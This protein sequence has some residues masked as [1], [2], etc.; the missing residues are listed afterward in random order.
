MDKDY[1][2]R[3][4]LGGEAYDLKLS[5]KAT[6]KITKRYGGLE[7]LGDKLLEADS[8]EQIIDEVVWL[9]TLLANQSIETFNF[10]HPDNQK[11]LLTEDAVEVFA[12]PK[13]LLTYRGAIIEALTK[14]TQRHIESEPD[15][16]NAAVG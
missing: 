10:K 16:K 3:I 11:S 12:T 9:V 6:K 14:G 2:S 1:T 15:P 13:D 8:F 4:V 7:K 5:L